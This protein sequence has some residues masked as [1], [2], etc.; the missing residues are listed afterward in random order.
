MSVTALNHGLIPHDITPS[1]RSHILQSLDIIDDWLYVTVLFNIPTQIEA[2]SR[3]LS[4]VPARTTMCCLYVSMLDRRL[5]DHTTEEGD[6]RLTPC[7]MK[8]CYWATASAISISL[9]QPFFSRMPCSS[10]G[11]SIFVLHLIQIAAVTFC[12]GLAGFGTE[13]LAKAIIPHPTDVCSAEVA[14]L[15]TAWASELITTLRL[16]K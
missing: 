9:L 6:P 14:H 4:L 8:I 16:H 12:A 15:I 1:H 10:I 7:R 13:M 3:F 2:L 11:N 5:S